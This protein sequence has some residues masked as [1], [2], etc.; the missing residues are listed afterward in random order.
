M[1]LPTHYRKVIARRFTNQFREAAEVVETEFVMPAAGEVAVRNLYAGVNATDVNVTTGSYTP[2]QQ[3]PIDLGL[4]VLAEVVAVGE[5]VSNVKVGDTVLAMKVGAGYREYGLHAAGRVFP[6]PDANPAYVAVMLSGLTAA[7]GLYPCGEIK[8]SDTVLVTAAAGGTGQFAVQ[9]AK[10][11]GCHVIGTCST[12]EKA[13]LLHEMGVDRVINYKQEDF[14]SVIK[15]EYRNQLDLVYESVGREMF[16]VALD[17]LAI[18]G[19]LVLIGAISEYIDGPEVISAPR[20]TMKLLPKSASIRGMFL[21]HW[22]NHTPE[23]MPKLISLIA[24]DQ[25]QITIDPTEFQ[26]VESVVDAVEH[27]HS[28]QSRGKVVVR[29]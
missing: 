16:D 28:G 11:E 20:V 15:S 12:D 26:G 14:A 24:Q 21:N 7:F 25:L 22:F 27:L 1:S 4:E 10:Q 5:G 13:A 3:P 8:A 29:F 18:R 17:N 19:R 23:Y 2:G 9:L 6:V